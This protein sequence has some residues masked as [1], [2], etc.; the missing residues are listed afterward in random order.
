MTHYELAVGSSNDWVTPVEVF[1]ALGCT[2]DM[3]VASPGR[4][5]VPWIPATKHLM[6]RG[7][8]T[9]W[10][11]FV[12]MNP[13]FGGRNALAPW[14]AKLLEHGDGI[15]CVPDRT[16]APWWRDHAPRFDH[17]LFCAPKIKFIEL[18][19]GARSSPAS[20]ISLLA[21]GKRGENALMR[22][23][24]AKLGTLWR[25]SYIEPS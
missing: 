4:R 21:I 22:A 12:W 6:R 9:R 24:N 3:D 1:V 13:P 16:S 10:E 25:P 18:N 20:G 17:A 2:F 5:K 23:W 8:E 15:A 14:L 7:L 11:G 19:G